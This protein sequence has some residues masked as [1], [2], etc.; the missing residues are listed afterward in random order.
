MSQGSQQTPAAA[1]VAAPP[2]PKAQPSERL[3]E[4][5]TATQEAA[6]GR[7]FSRLGNPMADLHRSFG[8]QAVARMAG[9]T[10]TVARRSVMPK[11]RI[12][13]PN[14]VFEQEADRVA[15]AVMSADAM[16]SPS[17]AGTATDAAQRKPLDGPLP[18]QRKCSACDAEQKRELQ[19]KPMPMAGGRAVMRKCSEC[20][21]K[22]QEVQRKAIAGSVPA[23][24]FA[25]QIQRTTE[26]DDEAGLAKKIGIGHE[27]ETGIVATKRDGEAETTPSFEAQLAGSHGGGAP[28]PSD[29]RGF[30][31]DRM[32]TDFSGVR[33]HTDSRAANMAGQINARAFT[34]GSDIYF[35]SG[36]FSPSTHDGR[37]LMAHELTH[38]VQQAGAAPSAAASSIQRDPPKDKKKEEEEYKT[39]KIDITSRDYNNAKHYLV[40]SISQIFSLSEEEAAA[41]IQLH[42]LVWE[43]KTYG[44]P[45]AGEKTGYVSLPARLISARQSDIDALKKKPGGI[46]QEAYEQ[47]QKSGSKGAGMG[48]PEPGLGVRPMEFT[49]GMG[50]VQVEKGTELRSDPAKA[51]GTTIPFSTMLVVVKEVGDYYFVSMEDGQFGYVLKKHVDMRVPE[52]KA[53]LH[54][55]K[56]GETATHIVKKYYGDFNTWGAD[57]RLY[58]LAL[59]YV[60]RAA[61]RDDAIKGHDYETAYTYANKALW[62]PSKE[63]TLYLRDRKDI[64]SGSLSYD[65]YQAFLDVTVGPPVFLAGLIH[66]ALESL[67]DALVGIVELIGMA[68]DLLKAIFQGTLGSK[69]SEL[70]DQIKNMDVAKLI[71]HGID[72]LDKKWNDPSLFKRWHYRGW[73]VG[74]ILMEVVT[75]FFTEGLIAGVKVVA[76][77]AKIAKFVEAIPV[78]KEVVNLAKTLKAE[79]KA[80]KFIDALKADKTVASALEKLHKLRT[81]AQKT[82]E[83]PLEILQDIAVEGIERLQK[84]SAWATERLRAL[85]R[86]GDWKLVRECLGCHSPC[87]VDIEEILKYLEKVGKEG[88]LGTEL[89]T[90]EQVLAA[91]PK[92]FDTTKIADYLD[93]HPA[94]MALIKEAK[95]TDQDFVP[96][97]KQL[98]AASK[99]SKAD[100][101]NSFTLYLTRII[102]AKT[103]PD[104]ERF[105]LVIEAMM[106]ADPRQGSALKGS[107]FENFSK[108][109]VQGLEGL[110]T[111]VPFKVPP[112]A[113]KTAREADFWNS[114]T[115]AL[116]DT[117]HSPAPPKEQFEDYV[118]LLGTTQNGGEV[119]SINYLFANK[120]WAEEWARLN[121]DKLKKAGVNVYYLENTSTAIGDTTKLLPK[122]LPVPP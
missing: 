120:A 35:G 97:V 36:Q 116:W 71:E 77:S 93:S 8:N 20:E 42:G 105:N 76:N 68:W 54:W 108:M 62:V 67:W 21:K 113:N 12:N 29:V 37:R 72:V 83:L 111:Q 91:L 55:I 13:A 39:F 66:G 41:Y 31:E 94:L 69:A 89:A 59:L 112:P 74:Y 95:L 15:E 27:E 16:G 1:P 44:G 49:P 100:S 60:N 24:T 52:P 87:K 32:G 57:Q 9:S 104:V 30:F 122:Q 106:K 121:P 10:L 73:L 56:S 3:F 82:L 5:E 23:T 33:F 14:D 64:S 6:D 28:M 7:P 119:K 81:W 25:P 34:Y 47:R 79:G 51:G 43:D 109:H 18:I 19:R 22:E 58:V 101:Y 88:K 48:G 85:V 99:M 117:K 114:S 107:M 103:G 40:T 17:D 38:T 92:V 45:P 90:K 26:V 75:L 118:R 98:E 53:R 78:L 86:R 70:W 102:P 2:Q 80:A 61:G 115:G 63:F 50:A 11:L 110:S 84:L 46:V 96:L 65:V 4:Q